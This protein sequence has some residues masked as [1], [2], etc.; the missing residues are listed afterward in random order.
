[1]NRTNDCGIIKVADGW[2]LCP[3]CHKKKMFPVKPTTV[4]RDLELKCN[5]C[6]SIVVLN[7]EAP[8]LVSAKTN[9]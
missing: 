2:A 8:E 9:A 6:G 5:R 7:I 4:V 1:M 3:N